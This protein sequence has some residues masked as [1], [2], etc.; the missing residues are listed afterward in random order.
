MKTRSFIYGYA[1]SGKT[2]SLL[3][4][5][6]S[7][8]GLNVCIYDVDGS[9]RFAG[10]ESPYY[11]SPKHITEGVWDIVVV[12]SITVL[13][14]HA[15]RKFCREKGISCADEVPYGKGHKEVAAKVMNFINGIQTEHLILV[16][17]CKTEYIETDLK[18]HKVKSIFLNK[19]IADSVITEYD[20]VAYFKNGNLGFTKKYGQYCK[21]RVTRAECMQIS[22]YI[23]TLINL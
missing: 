10:Y 16:G 18:T 22:D 21:S 11:V 13:Y 9:G 6:N 17:H 19:N 14:N 1:G 20:T 3:Q 12:D 4:A 5:I 8:Q 7:L 23:N 15:E 2:T